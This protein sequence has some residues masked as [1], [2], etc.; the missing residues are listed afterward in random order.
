MMVGS[1]SQFSCFH[2]VISTKTMM[3]CDSHPCLT[4]FLPYIGRVLSVITDIPR[5][6]L[7]SIN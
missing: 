4:S 2:D 7:I 1:S 3:I 6:N 5:K